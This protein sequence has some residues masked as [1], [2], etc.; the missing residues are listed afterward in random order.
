MTA[1]GNGSGEILQAIREIASK[2]LGIPESDI[3][4]DVELATLENVDSVKILRVVARLE[5][6]LGVQ[7]EDDDIF[8]L[9]KISDLVGLLESATA[10]SQ[11]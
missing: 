9:Q 11:Q 5:R 10:V 3:E 8:A 6:R 1:Q 4:P 7:I 2:E